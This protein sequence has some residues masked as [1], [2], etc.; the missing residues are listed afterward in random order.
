M[1]NSD[2][3]KLENTILHKIGNKLNEEG[4]RFSK[5][6]IITDDEI[7]NLLLKYFFS[8]F[9]Q[10]EYFNLYHDT[11]IKLNEIY[12]YVS[13]IFTDNQELFNQS[14]NIAKHLYEQSVHPKIK[15]GE[16]YVTYFKDCMLD[17]ENMDAIGIFKSETR[18][19]YLKVYPSS[20]GFKIDSET[21]ININKLEKGCLIFNTEAEKG[22]VVALVDNLSKGSEAQYWIDNFLHV[23]TRE[24]EY[25]HTQNA[26]N[27]CKNFVVESLPKE[28]DVTKA[29]QADMLNQSLQFFKENET[30]S[31]D[32]FAENVMKHPQII[33]TFKQYKQNYENEN[34]IKI[35]DDFDISETAVKKQSRVMKSVIK[36]DKNFHI[37]IHGKREMIEKGFDENTGMHFYKLFYKEEL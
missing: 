11:D 4:I 25:H 26:L 22:Y 23:K 16:I 24:D 14:V 2:F 5:S 12:S 18:D 29:D 1:I 6:P 17:G 32:N 34:E 15:N 8:P 20:D 31:L 28:Y 35:A 33:E 30:F 37:Y 21:G 19:T 13:A 10:N 3:A 27:L 7:N 9:K 36:L